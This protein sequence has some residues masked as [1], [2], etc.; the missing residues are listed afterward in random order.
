MLD[1]WH[2]KEKPVFTGI[3]RGIGGFGFGKAA[4]GG[5]G[6]T[7]T[8]NSV[9]ASGGAIQTYVDGST[10]YRL[11]IFGNGDSDFV[12][13][14][15]PGSIDIMVIGGGGSGAAS[16]G[17][18]DAGK[19]GGG[20]GGLAWVDAIPISPGTTCPITV[21]DGGQGHYGHDSGSTRVGRN[22]S[23][24]VF[25]IPSGPYTITGAGGGGGGAADTNGTPV[26]PVRVPN[27]NTN[28]G[29]PGGS[30]GGAGCRGSAN[31]SFTGGNAE[32]QTA[33][34]GLP[35]VTDYGAPGGN[36]VS[37]PSSGGGG[38]GGVGTAGSNQTSSDGGNG[39][40]G[41]NNFVGPTAAQKAFLL[42][43]KGLGMSN[44]NPHEYATPSSPSVYIGGG[45]AGA[46][47]TS[48]ANFSY[49]LS[50][51]GLGGG[52]RAGLGKNVQQGSPN[53]DSTLP[54][55]YWHQIGGANHHGGGGGGA[56]DDPKGPG[57]DRRRTSGG[58]G[59]RGGQGVVV[60]RYEVTEGTKFQ[61]ITA[62]GG[63]E[64]T[65]GDYK[66]HK[67]DGSGTNN[68]PGTFTVTQK[69]E[70]PKDNTIEVLVVG[71]GGSGGKW[72]GG[73]GGA[74][75][76]AHTY[77][78]SLEHP[79]FTGSGPWAIPLQTGGG[80]SVQTSNGVGNAGGDSY[81]GPTNLRLV[82]MGG[83]G[84]GTSLSISP[85]PDTI[86]N[87]MDGGSGGG[88]AAQNTN[89]RAG[90]GHQR[91]IFGS[92]PGWFGW[93]NRIQY[94]T[95]IVAYHYGH[96]GGQ[97]NQP[98]DTDMGGGGGAGGAGTNGGPGT[99]Y[100]SGQGHGGPG[101]AISITGSPVIYGGGGT[102]ASPPGSEAGAPGG[103][104]TGGGGGNTAGGAGTDGL[105]GGGGGCYSAG[106][107]SGRGGAGTVI[108]RYKYQ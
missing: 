6:G 19:G 33:N 8:A 96:S 21:G 13:T 83:G 69:A 75:G 80:G 27:A 68:A 1:K 39:G 7:S 78:Y 102:G 81:F 44:A 37:N 57:T 107:Q 51:G 90:F 100:S 86:Y 98:S 104:G 12:Y 3:A 79:A 28:N 66:I 25:V 53:L 82:G 30:G 106:P 52:G 58:F 87:S 2:K 5:G 4:G 14:S 59:G 93:S 24:S 47:G 23:N 73:G 91:D 84:G 26:S 89:G 43:T 61:Y 94:N 65:D 67:F 99:G 40:A 22:G 55:A 17:D 32:Q 76:V 20:S 60:V 92:D 72:S 74:G 34:P 9:V 62:S 63:V 46:P 15:G 10:T 41:L 70:D 103:G 101:I 36:A 42:G 18:Q 71:G 16:S 50:L 35:W 29:A 97:A 85:L 95:K 49:P 108:V 105:G 54:S 48:G 45:G 88:G 64:S 77:N 38:G 31:G 11:H 56:A